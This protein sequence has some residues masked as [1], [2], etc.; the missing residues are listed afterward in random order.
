MK[1]SCN[2]GFLSFTQIWVYTCYIKLCY[3]GLCN[4]VH[5]IWVSISGFLVH[6]LFGGFIFICM[7]WVCGLHICLYALSVYSMYEC[8]LV[9]MYVWIMYHLGFQRLDYVLVMDYVWVCF[10]GLC[11]TMKWFCSD[12]RFVVWIILWILSH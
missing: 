10:Y 9:D 1:P 7:H 11:F 4:E 6:I 2:L 12:Y 8:V 3:A 5:T